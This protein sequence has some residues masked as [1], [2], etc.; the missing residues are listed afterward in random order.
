[1]R[2]GVDLTTF[3]RI[4]LF[5][6]RVEI[7]KRKLEEFNG[8]VRGSNGGVA[9]FFGGIREFS[10]IQPKKIAGE[11]IDVQIVIQEIK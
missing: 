2:L 11:K 5:T 1:M 9:I 10:R 4:Y 8:V 7:I 6:S 3:P